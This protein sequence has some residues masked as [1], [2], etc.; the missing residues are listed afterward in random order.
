M[1]IFIF[2]HRNIRGAL[3]IEEIH[4]FKKK[5]SSWLSKYFSHN[6]QMICKGE[7]IV[8]RSTCNLNYLKALQ[9]L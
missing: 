7:H 8:K 4:P 3:L 6:S 5:K 2:P 9:L 1:N